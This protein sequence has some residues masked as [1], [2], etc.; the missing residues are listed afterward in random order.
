MKKAFL[1]ILMAAFFLGTGAAHALPVTVTYT[2]DNIVNAW[3]QDGA[4]PV[5]LGL[6]LNASN[7]KIADSATLDLD[8]NT[9]YQL[10][11]QVSNSGDPS[12]GNPAGFLAQIDLGGSQILSS[13]S[14]MYDA[15]GGDT[16]NFEDLSWDWSST[17]EYGNNGGSNIWTSVNGG[18]VM[19]IDTDAQWIWASTNF[20][21]M[22][23][24][25]Q[26]IFIKAEFTTPVA[27]PATLLL[28]GAGL[29]GVAG[30]R[31]KF[32]KG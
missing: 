3:Y 30:L 21:K 25:H 24:D 27:E 1:F 26:N 19:G 23:S 7:W 5:T 10:I 14:F 20:D 28:L 11:W 13:S 9:H 12:L 4:A 32:G 18:P 22:V 16:N 29:V 31:R 6:G 15:D 2:A 17:T 8:Y